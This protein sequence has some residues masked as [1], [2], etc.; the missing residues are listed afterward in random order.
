M[1]DAKNY[2]V[3]GVCIVVLL[4]SASY[5]YKQVF[6]IPSDFP[7][8]KNFTVNENESLKSVSNRLLEEKYISS[9]L[10]FRAGISFLGKDRAIQLGGYIFNTPLSL[11]GVVTTFVEGKPSAPLLSVT[12]PEG[13]TSLEIASIVTKA[14]PQVS[15]DMFAQV[16]AKYGADGK[17]FPSTYFLLPSYTAEDI[18]KIMLTTFTKKIATLGVIAKI[19]P[20]LTGEHDVLV[21]ASIL[22]GEAKTQADMKIVAGILLSRMTLGMPLQVDVAMETYKQKGLPKNPINN[23]GLTAIDAVLHPTQTEYLFYITGNDGQM[24]YAKT[25][26]EHK[27]N[28]KKYLR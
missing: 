5:F 3:I 23:P 12:I 8:G 9:P 4:L 13:S 6:S 2:T 7:V 22:E 24:Y 21:L 15:S 17:L 28:I 27:R 19:N 11:F 20:P 26:D 10:L 1:R 14:L 16:I 25:F 18:V